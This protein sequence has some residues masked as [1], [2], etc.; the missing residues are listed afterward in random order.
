[1]KKNNPFS[2]R[3]LMFRNMEVI[4]IQKPG[5]PDFLGWKKRYYS[6]IPLFAGLHIVAE[7]ISFTQH[8]IITS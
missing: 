3:I 4:W 5:Q 2:H 1:M 8:F 7:Q 6:K